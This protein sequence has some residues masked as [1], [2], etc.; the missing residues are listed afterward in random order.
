MVSNITLLLTPTS[1]NFRLVTTH[2]TFQQLFVWS[3]DESKSR[4]MIL[5][6]SFPDHFIRRISLIPNCSMLPGENL[7]QNF[8]HKCVSSEHEYN[9]EHIEAT[10]SKLYTSIY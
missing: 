5:L 10:S 9:Y 8:G 1:N 7:I 6:V 3:V 2:F 4:W